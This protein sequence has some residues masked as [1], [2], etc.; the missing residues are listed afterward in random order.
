MAGP[1]GGAG[2]G[3]LPLGHPALPARPSYLRRR[4]HPRV[5]PGGGA[6]VVIHEEGPAGLRVDLDLPAGGQRLGAAVHLRRRRRAVRG[7]AHLT[8]GHGGAGQGRAAL[9]AAL[10]AAGRGRGRGA[11]TVWKR[12]RGGRRRGRDQGRD[13]E[14][15]EGGGRPRSRRLETSGR[16]QRGRADPRGTGE[17]RPGEPRAGSC[18]Q[19]GQG[20]AAPHGTAGGRHQPGRSPPPRARPGAGSPGAL[21]QAA[22]DPLPLRE[23]IK[24]PPQNALP[25]DP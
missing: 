4:P 25:R 7:S 16:V 10:S 23:N 1:A 2:P 20:R 18:V 8:A 6:A 15:E 9:S 3:P 21:C 17:G 24:A 14:E 22:P 11:G 13:A 5:A 19:A 12:R